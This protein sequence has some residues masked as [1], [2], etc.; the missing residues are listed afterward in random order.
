MVL[1]QEPTKA[2]FVVAVVMWGL[3]SGGADGDD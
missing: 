3:H 1:L 2:S